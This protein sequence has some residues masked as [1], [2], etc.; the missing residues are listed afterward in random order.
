MVKHAVALFLQYATGTVV[1]VVLI[2]V[3]LVNP[4]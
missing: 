1:A 4:L 2:R 3:I